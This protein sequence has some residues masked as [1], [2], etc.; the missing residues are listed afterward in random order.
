MRI[1]TLFS[2]FILKKGYS[3]FTVTLHLYNLNIKGIG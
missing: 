2:C 1:V 3:H